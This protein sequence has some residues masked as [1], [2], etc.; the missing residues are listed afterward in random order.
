MSTLIPTYDTGA[1]TMMI[2]MVVPQPD[3]CVTEA[4]LAGTV[5]LGDLN[6]PFVLGTLSEFLTH[7]R[8]GRH[9]YRSVAARTL[10]PM[11]KRKYEEF[12]EET[13]R[14][15]TLLEE[16]IVSMGGDPQYVSP[17]A[18]AIEKSDTGLVQST[19]MLAGSVDHM[20]AEA[21]ML[22]AVM[23]AESVDHA[24]W[25]LLQAMVPELPAGP[26]QELARRTVDE[27][28]A[29]EDEHLTWARETRARMAMLQAKS[30]V[31][32]KVGMKAEETMARIKSWFE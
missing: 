6:M 18:R 20:T 25:Q 3:R 2:G 9:L 5:Q 15:V 14:H 16:L 21:V 19:F 7:E 1:T 4:D 26:I 24:N 31:A 30:S 32:A 10:N 17:A 11:L 23:I 22:T 13:E 27:V 12:G 8:C 29:Q 28:E